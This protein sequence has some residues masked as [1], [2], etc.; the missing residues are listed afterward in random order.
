M[1]KLASVSSNN[2]DVE[3]LTKDVGIDVDTI[4]NELAEID[5]GIIQCNQ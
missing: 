3:I 1:I 4:G 5:K 2:G